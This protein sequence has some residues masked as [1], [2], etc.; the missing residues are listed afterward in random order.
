MGKKLTNF[1]SINAVRTTLIYEYNKRNDINSPC[2]QREI[3]NNPRLKNI[4]N[5]RTKKHRLSSL[6][7]SINCQIN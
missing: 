2:G 1:A 5:K 6:Q 7:S 4:P 3:Y